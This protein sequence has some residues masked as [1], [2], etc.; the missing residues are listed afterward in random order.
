MGISRGPRPRETGGF[1]AIQPANVNPAGQF[2]SPRTGL[3]CPQSETGFRAICCSNLPLITTSGAFAP[4]SFFFAG[5][6]AKDGIGGRSEGRFRPLTVEISTD[7]RAAQAVNL[8]SA[9]VTDAGIPGRLPL[10][11]GVVLNRIEWGQAAPILFYHL[12]A[13]LAFL[14]WTFSW[15]G[16][17]VAVIVA[18]LSGLLGINIGYHRLLT[19]RGFPLSEMARACARGHR[20]L[21]CGGYTGTLGRR[22]PPASSARRRT[23]RS[24]Q[25]AGEF[26]LGAC[27]LAGGEEPRVEPARNLRSLCQGH[28]A[29]P[30]LCGAG[31]QLAAAQ[32]HP[33]PVGGIFRR[34]LPC[35]IGAGRHCDAGRAVRHQHPDLGGCS[36][37][38]YSSGIRLGR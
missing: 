10:P 35:G 11:A 30:V 8:T 5:V 38:R 25:P 33:H 3:K 36:C 26:S 16:V 12:V 17:I 20:H 15:T 23:A 34:G 13:L 22:A 29:R 18:R 2:G 7:R 9:G 31:T 6:C 32:D 4:Q 24:A 37:A 19:H 21:L 14:P 1:Y 27:R 28:P